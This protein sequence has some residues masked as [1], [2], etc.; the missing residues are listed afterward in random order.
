[1]TFPSII[2]SGSPSAARKGTMPPKSRSTARALSATVPPRWGG[3]STAP[4]SK[5]TTSA[6]CTN[7]STSSSV[8]RFSASRRRSESVCSW[9]LS[10][11][12]SLSL[13]LFALLGAS[14]SLSLCL[15]LVCNVCDVQQRWKGQHDQGYLAPR[16]AAIDK[17]H[18]SR[19]QV[20][21]GAARGAC[22]WDR[23]A[24]RFATGTSCASDPVSQ[25]R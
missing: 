9:P 20:H 2:R 16:S 11:A 18:T 15:S 14:L 1:M 3:V 22:S 6:G 4:S 13:S 21:R 24:R 12:L 10:L 5:A 17:T 23:A 7:W 25:E 19:G 8:N